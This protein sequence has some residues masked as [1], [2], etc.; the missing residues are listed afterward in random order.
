[1]EELFTNENQI[2]QNLTEEL[3]EESA[4]RGTQS[5]TVVL[6]FFVKTI[7]INMSLN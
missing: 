4:L 5:Y 1:M 7:R 2:T 3:L 6:E